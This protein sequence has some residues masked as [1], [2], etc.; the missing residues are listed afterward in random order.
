[1][2]LEHFNRVHDGVN[3]VYHLGNLSKWIEKHTYLEGKPFSY[4][5]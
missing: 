1:M 4:V 3:A 2:L 5:G